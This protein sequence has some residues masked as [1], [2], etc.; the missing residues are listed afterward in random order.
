MAGAEGHFRYT[1]DNGTNYKAK[2]DAS[3]AAVTGSGCVANTTDPPLPRAVK[4]RHVWVVDNSDVTGGRV[5]T[6]RRRKL[7][8]CTAAATLYTGAQATAILPDFSVT[9]SANVTFNAQ[10]I[11]GER[12]FFG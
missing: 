11:I 7:V 12:R 1:S 6:G 2:L 9:P 4:T 10:G 8:V 5:P 3:N